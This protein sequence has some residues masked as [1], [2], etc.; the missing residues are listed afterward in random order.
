MYKRLSYTLNTRDRAFPGA[1]T[2]SVLPFESMERGDVCNT[3]QVTLF[4]HFGTHMDGPNHFNGD[5]KQLYELE[6][7]RFIFERPLLVDIPKAEGEMVLPEDLIPF[8][9]QIMKPDLLLIR[10]GFSRM[11][12]EDSGVYSAQG[13]CVSADAAR[14]I[15]E[16]YGNLKAV[17][18]DWISLSSPLHIEDGVLA[19]QI[20]LGKQGNAPV[21]II[22]DIDL[23]GLDADK[24]ESVFALPVFIEGIDSAPVTILAK[25]KDDSEK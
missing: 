8:E 2:I 7:S 1:P 15:T 21:L 20:M 9:S 12:E 13:P 4:N 11:R 14:L 24:L 25:I 17:G 18:L 10:S 3:F 23:R 6:L 19:H 5:G 16:K 22:E